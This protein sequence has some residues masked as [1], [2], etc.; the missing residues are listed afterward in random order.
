MNSG[1][2]THLAVQNRD[3]DEEY[4]RA[5]V[6]GTVNTLTLGLSSP[7]PS[8]SDSDFA[9]S[10]DLRHQ[11]AHAVIAGSLVIAASSCA[12]RQQ[13]V[14]EMRPDQGAGSQIVDGGTPDAG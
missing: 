9:C 6:G 7:S 14:V 13:D 8:R 3:E 2:S 1:K 5:E 4:R 11:P 12:H 10:P